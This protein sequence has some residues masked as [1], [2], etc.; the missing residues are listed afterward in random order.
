MATSMQHYK[1]PNPL[2]PHDFRQALKDAVANKKPL[3]GFFMVLSGLDL[4]R[5]VA[6]LGF[7][8]WVR[9]QALG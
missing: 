8:W 2:L 6:Q 1:A 5:F 7:D 3:L 4:T 9:S